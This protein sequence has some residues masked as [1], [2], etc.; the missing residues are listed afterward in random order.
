MSPGLPALVTVTPTLALNE[1]RSS[2]PSKRETERERRSNLNQPNLTAFHPPL[3]ARASVT[4]RYTPSFPHPAT[5]RPTTVI[6]TTAST[7]VHFV[8]RWGINRGGVGQRRKARR[9]ARGRGRG[10]GQKY[11]STTLSCFPASSF[12]VILAVKLN[13][14]MP[15]T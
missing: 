1:F 7:S 9:A 14:Q 5:R 8:S 10:R 12:T 13:L 15:S 6:I 2:S 11:C 4:M 3:C